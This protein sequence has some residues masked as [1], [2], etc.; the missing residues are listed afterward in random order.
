MTLEIFKSGSQLLQYVDPRHRERE[1][2]LVKQNRADAIEGTV[3]NGNDAIRILERD[4]Q[5]AIRVRY[6]GLDSAGL[7]ITKSFGRPINFEGPSVVRF[8]AVKMI[9]RLRS[10]AVFIS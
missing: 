10:F 7:L 4:C 1:V 9:I 8:G 2:F 5:I 3:V 6:P